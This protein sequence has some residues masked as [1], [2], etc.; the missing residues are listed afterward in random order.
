MLNINPLLDAKIVYLLGI[1][2][3]VFLFLIAMSCRCLVGNKIGKRL[4]KYGW[5]IKIS[6]CHG[7]FW[8]LFFFSILAHAILA[9]IVYGNPFKSSG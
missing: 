4:V 9:F 3:I 8:W 1:A 6:R 2:N 5:F 7:Y